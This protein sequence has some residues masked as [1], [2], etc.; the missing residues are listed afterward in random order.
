MQCR[1]RSR[2]DYRGTL[3]AAG[4]GLGLLA[5]CAASEPT[6][7]EHL[8]AGIS[9]EAPAE[10]TGSV[11]AMPGSAGAKAPDSSS[12]ANS[13]PVAGPALSGIPAEPEPVEP[14]NNPTTPDVPDSVV[15]SPAAAASAEPASAVATIPALPTSTEVEPANQVP[16][17][18]VSTAPVAAEPEISAPAVAPATADVA[19]SIP[20]SVP[21]GSVD[22]TTAATE[23]APA[24]PAEPA[25]T[26]VTTTAEPGSLSAALEQVAAADTTATVEA[27][28]DWI[29]SR[30]EAIS[31]MPG[32]QMTFYKQERVEDELQERET[33]LV[34][35]RHKP[36]SIY[37]RHSAPEAVAGQEAIFVTGQNDGKLIGHGVG[38]RAWLGT[39][40]LRIDSSL[41]MD[42]NLYPITHLGILHMAT[43]SVRN[44]NS[45]LGR[46]NLA[47]KVRA[48]E[49]V[50]GRDCT[51]VEIRHTRRTKEMPFWYDERYFD[52]E[53]RFPVRYRKFGWPDEEG[54][55]AM[56]LEDY[57]HAD[58]KLNVEL[59][60]RDFSRDNPDY[61]F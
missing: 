14:A 39:M 51:C 31:D 60:D 48:D 10:E 12:G 44:I 46:G 58:L 21:A 8:P 19:S 27:F 30:L 61:D 6:A 57:T 42:G 45:A 32:Y 47:V 13:D 36:F 33:M 25:A 38:L 20:A 18:P 54:G 37:L 52:D 34:K 56:L 43:D 11:T 3:V 16:A 40:K 17:E 35:I 23:L 1:T 41:A 9:A 55:P 29:K 26:L 53:Y 5:G 15:A 7:D 2:G 22:T 24:T 49:Q 50:S 4:L 59:T 28:R